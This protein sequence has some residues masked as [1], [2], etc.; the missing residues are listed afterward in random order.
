MTEYSTDAIL[1]TY[2]LDQDHTDD[3]YAS[4]AEARQALQ[5]F[6]LADYLGE[7]DESYV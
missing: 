7:L 2:S 3:F 5:G 4:L 1:E 6:D